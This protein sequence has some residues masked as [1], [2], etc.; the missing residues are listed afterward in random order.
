MEIEGEPLLRCWTTFP[1]PLSRLL[2]LSHTPKADATTIGLLETVRASVRPC[3]R[4]ELGTTYTGCYIQKSLPFSSFHMLFFS[5]RYTLHK[6]VPLEKGTQPF[7][8]VYN[9][10]LAQVFGR[11]PPHACN[12]SA[13]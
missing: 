11:P 3:V 8:I 4:K 9:R 1:P 2:I 6:N 5:I 7:V 12:H 13:T 10:P